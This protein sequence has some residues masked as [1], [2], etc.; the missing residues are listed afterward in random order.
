MQILIELQASQKGVIHSNEEAKRSWQIYHLYELLSKLQEDGYEIHSLYG[1]FIFDNAKR[2]ALDIGE[3][4]E[5][6]P[7][8]IEV[9]QAVY[10]TGGKMAVVDAQEKYVAF[11]DKYFLAI[12]YCHLHRARPLSIYRT[13]KHFNA[14]FLEESPKILH[15][16]YS[17]QFKEFYGPGAKPKAT[18]LGDAKVHRD[19]FAISGSI[20]TDDED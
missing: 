9:A 2:E 4:G 14:L 8:S 18:L 16:L 6:L 11:A 5:I 19:G 12:H 20:P 10:E 13:L 7:A 15:A 1:N 17:L 3:P